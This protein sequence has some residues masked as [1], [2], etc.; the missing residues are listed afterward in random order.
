MQVTD[1]ISHDNKRY[2]K[3][4]FSCKYIICDI[5]FEAKITVE[6]NIWPESQEWPDILQSCI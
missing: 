3:N 5:F 1:S 6:I 2:P 4:R